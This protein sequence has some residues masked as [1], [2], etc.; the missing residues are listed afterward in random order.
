M[1]IYP[2]VDILD[3]K[4]VRL[5]QGR[6]DKVTSYNS[7]PLEAAKRWQDEGAQFLHVVDLNGAAEGKPKNLNSLDRIIEN[8]DIPVQF[9]GGV[10]D[11]DSLERVLGLGVKRAVLGTSIINSPDFVEEVLP[12][13]GSLLAAGLDS[14]EG[15]VAIEGWTEDTEKEVVEVAKDLDNGGIS[16]IIFTDI[17]VDGTQDGI[18]Y[19][20]IRSL[21]NEIETQVIAS[22]GVATIDDIYR[23][24]TIESSGVSGV[25]IGRALYEGSLSLPRAL[26]VAVS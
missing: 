10:R 8:I 23:L 5:M 11:R 18:N 15:K 12:K 7:D 21:A 13:Y 19:N 4:C 26:E 2:A 16:A 3:G 1:I 25:I 20:A 17:N 9:G 22:G 14:R 6:Y 24:K